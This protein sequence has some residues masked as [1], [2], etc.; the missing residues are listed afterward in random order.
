MRKEK[1]I[2]I[3]V[4]V[5]LTALVAVVIV[6]SIILHSKNKELED[7]K[8]KN[9]MVSPSQSDENQENKIILKNFEIFIDKSL[10]IW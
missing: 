5:V 4:W 3:S 1:I 7:L 10:D 8:N 2:K 6:T 9:D